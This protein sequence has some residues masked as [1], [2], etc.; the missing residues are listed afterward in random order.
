MAPTGNFP[1]KH[2]H[3]EINMSAQQAAGIARALIAALGG[4]AVAKGWA[5]ATVVAEIGGIAATI[6][7]AVWSYRSKRPA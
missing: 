2:T 1:P 4:F 7:V 3:E 6:T 5:D